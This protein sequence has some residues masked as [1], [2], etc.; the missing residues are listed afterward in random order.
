M[1]HRRKR[2]W[3]VALFANCGSRYIVDFHNLSSHLTLDNI[4]N[5]NYII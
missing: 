3:D 4:S 5:N 2:E 1:L